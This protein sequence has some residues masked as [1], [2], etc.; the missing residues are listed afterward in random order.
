M[1]PEGED[2]RVFLHQMVHK[3]AAS[4]IILFH[5][6]LVERMFHKVPLHIIYLRRQRLETPIHLTKCDHRLVKEKAVQ[7]DRRVQRHNRFSGFNLRL[8]RALIPKH[9][10]LVSKSARGL[11]NN[12]NEVIHRPNPGI[13]CPHFRIRR[14]LKRTIKKTTGGRL[15]SGRARILVCIRAL[16]R[17]L[18]QTISSLL[19]LLASTFFLMC[20]NPPPIADRKTLGEAGNCR[21]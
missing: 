19:P 8:G 10:T 17:S 3:I 14:H 4:G 20:E 7:S 18:G 21:S 5:L 9:E 13:K 6:R 16:W 1:P 12:L 11:I 2:E 15:P